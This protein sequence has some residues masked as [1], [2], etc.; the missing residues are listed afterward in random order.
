MSL[1]SDLSERLLKKDMNS[2]PFQ[3]Q[4]KKPHK[5]FHKKYF[6]IKDIKKL[7][8][9]IS[10]DETLKFQIANFK[11]IQKKEI[12][13]ENTFFSK[14]DYSLSERTIKKND[15]M[16][17][18]PRFDITNK[19]INLMINDH[20]FL[21]F[22]L[23]SY[24][25]SIIIRLYLFGFFIYNFLQENDFS[26]YCLLFFN[27][28]R[29]LFAIL[30]A[31]IFCKSESDDDIYF[32]RISQAFNSFDDSSQ[33]YW[34]NDVHYDFY[35][36]LGEMSSLRKGSNLMG[37][38]K[39]KFSDKNKSILKRNLKG[40]IKRIILIVTP[41][42]FLF[43]ILYIFFRKQS[44]HLKSIKILV[45]LAEWMY[46]GLEIIALILCLVAMGMKEGMENGFLHYEL[47]FERISWLILF[48]PSFFYIILAVYLFWT[49]EKKAENG[50]FMFALF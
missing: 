43:I 7:K 19:F 39:S 48:V 17:R 32:N 10:F 29:I 47:N 33:N 24:I 49:K 35:I 4:A 16:E 40:I 46:R 3:I 25:I 34:F 26:L 15:M 11:Y 30:M 18:T 5:I 45:I 28:P 21:N 42:E 23:Y 20:S 14:K 9:T 36:K 2:F 13:N 1:K 38:L 8:K 31:K 44:N 50:R 41:V 22:C 12:L 6:E 37:N 27:V